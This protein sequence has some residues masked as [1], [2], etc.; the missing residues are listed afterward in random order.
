MTASLIK[1]VFSLLT[2]LPLLLPVQTDGT[3]GSDAIFGVRWF[4]G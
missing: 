4:L 3:I 2:L 1:F